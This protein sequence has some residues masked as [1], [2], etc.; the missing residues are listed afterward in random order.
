MRVLHSALMI[1]DEPGVMNQME[2]EE[3]A[4]KLLGLKW[5]SRLYCPAS[6]ALLGPSLIKSSSSINENFFKK[7]NKVLFWL[8]FRLDYYKWLKAKSE[9]YD[10]I[11]LRHSKYD[12]FRL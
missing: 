12:P 1:G 4:A 10:V 8:R 6:S 3:K 7:F 9:N 5:H 11:L 2:L